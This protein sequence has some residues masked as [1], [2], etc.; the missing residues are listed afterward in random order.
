MIPIRPIAVHF[1][2]AILSAAAAPADLE[3][4]LKP[5]AKLVLR[6]APPISE[7]QIVRPYA[8]LPPTIRFRGN[9]EKAF[10]VLVSPVWSLREDEPNPTA[11]E[12]RRT[13]HAASEVAAR[14]AVET[15]FDFVDFKSGDVYRTY[16]SATDGVED[17][18]YR[19]LMQGMLAVANYRV[20]FTI[21]SNGKPAAIVEPALGMLKTVKVV[22]EGRG[23]GRNLGPY[24]A[25]P[26][27]LLALWVAVVVIRRKFR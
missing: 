16:F 14:T 21:L 4:P 18:T 15:S 23:K 10:R 1:A 7:Y 2:F 8:N 11:E 6:Q 13:V 17:T 5:G 3:V 9:D 22:E 19:N 20:S 24:L 12:I 26:A 25:F 27:A